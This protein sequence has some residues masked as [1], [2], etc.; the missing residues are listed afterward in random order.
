MT[1]SIPVNFNGTSIDVYILIHTYKKTLNK[2]YPLCSLLIFQGDISLPSQINT[3][4]GALNGKNSQEE[5]S[6]TRKQ[7]FGLGN[8]IN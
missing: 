3:L 6:L 7:D 8:K 2:V 4:F 1:C 5:N